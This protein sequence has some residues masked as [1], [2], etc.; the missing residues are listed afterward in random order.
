[1]SIQLFSHNQTAY[2]SALAMLDSCGKAAIVHPTGTGKSFIAF[3]LCEDKKDETVCWL[4][5]SEFYKQQIGRALSASKD[6]EPI[7]FDIVNNIE[8]LYSIGT[9]E[10]EMPVI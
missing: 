2:D 5:P 9:I 4:S 6:R 7:I 8:N 10:Q 1:M 3:K